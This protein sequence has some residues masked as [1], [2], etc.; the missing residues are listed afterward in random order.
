MFAQPRNGFLFGR[1][2]RKLRKC[3]FARLDAAMMDELLEITDAR[4]LFH[5][6][7]ENQSSQKNE[8]GAV[9]EREIGALHRTPVVVVVFQ[10]DQ[11]RRRRDDDV[12]ALLPMALDCFGDTPG[13]E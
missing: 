7:A 8:Q 5:S 1:L 3:A 2:L 6:S 12:T 4:N 13:E 10:F 11:G 9:G